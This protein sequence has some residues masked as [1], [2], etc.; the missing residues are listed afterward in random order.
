MLDDMIMDILMPVMDGVEAT[1]KIR[2]LGFKGPIVGMTA[3]FDFNDKHR[4]LAAGAT[5]V[6]LKPFQ[7]TVLQ[8][9]L[10]RI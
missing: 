8:S 10:W 4:M 9:I 1:S 3:S 5:K 7:L 2:K 6:L